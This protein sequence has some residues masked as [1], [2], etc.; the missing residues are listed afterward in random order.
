MEEIDSSPV[1]PSSS[2]HMTPEMVEKFKKMM[3]QEKR[4]QAYNREYMR[5]LRMNKEKTNQI[6]R[7]YRERKKLRELQNQSQ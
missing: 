7:A 4:K 5:K 2:M 6:Q 3:E 1:E